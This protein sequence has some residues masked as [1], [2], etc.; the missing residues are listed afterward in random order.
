MVT[1][2][3]PLDQFVPP[4]R[5]TVADDADPPRHRAR[6]RPG[7]LGVPADLVERAPAPRPVAVRVERLRLGRVSRRRSTSPSTS[8]RSSPRSSTSARTWPCTC[9]TGSDSWFT[10]T[11][12]DAGR[13]A[14]VAA[15]AVDDSSGRRPVPLLESWIDEQARHAGDHR[16]LAHRVRSRCWRGPTGRQGNARSRDSASGTPSSS[17]PHRRSRSTRARRD[18]G[19]R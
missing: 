9:E 7:A 12:G 11:A 1:A 3:H 2:D 19:S 16:H 14:G 15:P 10:A 8:A 13:A 6:S 18:R 17:A 5:L 4:R